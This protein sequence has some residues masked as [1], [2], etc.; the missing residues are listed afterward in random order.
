ML[1]PDPLPAGSPEFTDHV[2]FS[3]WPEAGGSPYHTHIVYFKELFSQG[4]EE[5]R[6]SSLFPCPCPS[7]L[8]WPLVAGALATGDRQKQVA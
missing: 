1:H 4:R 7:F 3:K 5:P 6:K 8:G 2:S